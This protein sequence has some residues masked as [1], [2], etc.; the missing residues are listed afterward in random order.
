MSQSQP[1]RRAAVVVPLL[2]IVVFLPLFRF[3]QSPAFEAIRG[4]DL[5]LIFAS[6]MAFGQL[7][8]ALVR[9]LRE[10]AAAS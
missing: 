9:R 10:K 7:V 4:V 5:A 1:E 8:A 2:I 6:G 3:F